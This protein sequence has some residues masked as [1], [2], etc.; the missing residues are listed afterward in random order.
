MGTKKLVIFLYLIVFLFNSCATSI[1]SESP[2]RS[3]SQKKEEG[4]QTEEI[5]LRKVEPKKDLEKEVSPLP[6]QEFQKKWR[7][8]VLPPPPLS[9]PVEEK[10][11]ETPLD[12][13]SL[14]GIKEPVILNVENMPLSDFII[15]VLGD[16]LK[17]AFL[18]DENVKNMRNPVTLRM[19][20]ALPPEDVLNIV[21]KYLETFELKI[22]A[23]GKI[24][25]ITKPKPKTLPIPKPKI[26]A[27]I[28]GDEIPES[29]ATI[30]VLYPLKY[31][32]T[33]D[34][35]QLIRE[36]F[37]D[38]VKI[39]SFTS[40]NALQFIGPAFQIKKIIEIVKILDIP[41][42]TNRKIYLIKLTYWDVESFV[43]QLS[44]LLSKLGYPLAKQIKEPGIVLIPIKSL[45]SMI[46]AFPDEDSF[47]YTLEW[48]KK[49][50][51]PE[52]AGTEE[53]FYIYKPKFSK[54]TD[55]AETIQKLLTGTPA[56]TPP[57]PPPPTPLLP[58]TAPPGK[59]SPPTSAVEFKGAKISADD[60]RNFLMIVATPA[61]Y[62]QILQILKELDRPPKQV[63]IEASIIEL[64]LNDE[65][66]MGLE[67]Y[68]KNKWSGNFTLS[69]LFN[70]ISGTGL[71]YT[72]IS[73]TE[74]FNLLL[75]IF[76][77]KGLT[78][79]LST[80]RLM[81][82][83]NQ[84]ATIQVGYDVP[85]VTGE[86]T[87]VRYI[88]NETTGVFRTIQYRN[89]G[90]ILKV[91]PTIFAEDTLQLELTQEVSAVEHSL[92]TLDSPTIS[93]RRIQTSVV[94]GNG[95]TIALG[96]LISNTKRKGENKVPL[97]GDIPLIGNLFKSQS[98]GDF[99][100]ELLILLT[101]YIIQNIEEATAI[102]KELKD[103][104]KWYK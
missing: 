104:I 86:V 102:T 13:Q 44:D 27:L 84:E 103:Q 37:K 6:S 68:I 28:I 72:F 69:Q 80:P 93:T 16:L 98:K 51:S 15:Y 23:K 77:S 14:V 76:A 91:K 66:R 74:K 92:S 65:L 20:K 88:S 89:T 52:S 96:G 54:A 59:T 45:N 63:L 39:G 85:V 49:L 29:P 48:I 60:K 18:I 2:L 21:I 7:V 58:G 62:Q 99:K 30:M 33:Q 101:P 83:D 73:E 26:E 97:L 10:K 67:W 50:D 35:D 32:K 40:E 55:L 9:P 94:A 53:R 8:E 79:I 1:K 17:V 75:N 70:V 11:E 24:L 43:N 22:E 87:S 5:L 95:K 56:K 78:N 71:T 81:V 12:A 90:I 100:T 41:F 25:S 4:N 31:V 46:C 36:V 57:S 82:L 19:P 34:L 64:T 61:F 3:S 42:F 47:K 38:G